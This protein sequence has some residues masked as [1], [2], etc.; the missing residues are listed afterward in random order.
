MSDSKMIPLNYTTY[1][2]YFEDKL[3]VLR[4][5]DRDGN[6]VYTYFFGV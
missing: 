5:S 1:D 4:E 6:S 2:S 3:T